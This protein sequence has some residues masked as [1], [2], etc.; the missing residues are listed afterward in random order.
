MVLWSVKLNS[1]TCSFFYFGEGID[2]DY[3]FSIV[4]PRNW[5]FS[6]YGVRGSHNLHDLK[7]RVNNNT[8]L[9]ASEYVRIFWKHVEAPR[10]ED[11]AVRGLE[12]LP[13]HD[14]TLRASPLQ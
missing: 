6:T 1:T 4:V 9:F 2:E 12:T 11:T 5:T 3:G 14:E 10:L 7:L 8:S 13:P